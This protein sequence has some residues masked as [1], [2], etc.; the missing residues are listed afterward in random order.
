MRFDVNNYKAR[1]DGRNLQMRIL[2]VKQLFYEGK[3]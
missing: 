2:N 3:V 1:F